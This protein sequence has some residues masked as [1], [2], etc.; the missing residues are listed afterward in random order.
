MDVLTAVTGLHFLRRGQVWLIDW[1]YFNPLKNKT[2]RTA[3]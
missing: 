1:F 2:V 3:V